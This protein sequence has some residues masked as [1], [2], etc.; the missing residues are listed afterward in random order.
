MTT[1]L[2]RLFGVVPE[3]LPK[4][5]AFVALAAF[6]QA[7]VAIGI[8]ASDALFLSELGVAW[9]PV[10]FVFLPVF[11]LI[12]AP[13]YAHL[14]GRYGIDRVFL[15]TLCFLMLGGIGFGVAFHYFADRPAWLLFTAK[16]YTG[17]WFVALYTLFWNFADDYFA[18]LDGKR[19]WG[20]IAAG[21][22][23]GAMIGAGIVT[24]LAGFLDPGYLFVVWAFLAL[25]T[26]PILRRIQRFTKLDYWIAESEFTSGENAGI[27]AILGAL[28]TNRFALLL[29][30]I[31]FLLVSLG[32]MLEFLSFGVFEQGRN[33]AELATF[34]G[35]LYAIAAAATLAM[36]LVLFSRIVRR[37]GVN[38][39]AL[40]VP[41]LFLVAFIF[42]YLDPGMAAA[43]V[44]FYVLQTFFVSIE[45][46]NINLLFNGLP[47]RLRKQLRTFI[48]A[49]GEPM[50]MAVAGCFLLVY[51][52]N[53]G[54]SG[55]ALAGIVV[56][57]GAV[58][59][60]FLIRSDYAVSLAA[61]LREGWLD[62]SAKGLGLAS[63]QV[64]AREREY[65]Y[66]QAREG[67]PEDRLFA[68]EML[69][70][71]GDRRLPRLLL[72]FLPSARPQD[73]VRLEP[74]IDALLRN[75]DDDILAAVLL[76]LERDDTEVPAEVMV[77][78][79]AAGVIPRKPYERW[80]EATDVADQTLAAIA[81]W[82]NPR[83]DR[84]REALETVR[85]LLSTEGE[86]R[87]W[88]L[89][90]LGAFR[91][92]P[93]AI[94]LEPWVNDADDAVRLEAL[95]ALLKLAPALSALPPTVI[96]RLP[97]AT[98]E[99]RQLLIRIVAEVGD[100]RCVDALLRAA[101]G[102]LPVEQQ[103]A[104]DA[105]AGLGSK[106][107]PRVVSALR[108]RE[109]PYVSRDIAARV[110][111]RIAP[112]QLQSI[113]HELVRGELTSATDENTNERLD[114]ALHLLSLSK[115][116]PEFPLIR[117]NLHQGNQRD[118]ANAVETIQQYVP[119]PTFV[120]LLPLISKVLARRGA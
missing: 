8:T 84:T 28:R 91:H 103:T 3:E 65:L 75:P 92:A 120:R 44:G 72:A 22:S 117:T 86:P 85:A 4:L 94:E 67:D 109:M 61:N 41:A 116:L 53:I 106:A 111:E 90:A 107:T 57:L 37:I 71:L 69:M 87:L 97:Q 10:V 89:R 25:L 68:L 88:A 18:I 82:H 118:R 43:L 105:I 32:A 16:F 29:T 54:V 112:P 66:R 5:F 78:F 27:R 6:L 33:A 102:Y 49:I 36:N 74:I 15:A 30:V 31:C 35:S 73:F 55:V 77:A 14:L 104:A 13:V 12:Y 98:G 64:S 119:H 40:I 50:A 96:A 51:A 81:H 38:N 45:Y 34:L 76:W 56:A 48:E 93:L 113:A 9:L 39:T 21:S 114:F 17:L 2:L 95:R 110:L 101:A 80:V 99:E 7:G 83:I 42:F 52:G 47:V 63:R 23:L 26:I 62:F 19:L 11:T 20:I 46:N 100:T 59:V 115:I 24:S 58:F 60:A 108:D 79:L 70:N 1:N